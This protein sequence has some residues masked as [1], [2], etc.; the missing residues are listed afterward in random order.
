MPSAPPVRRTECS[1]EPVE[2]ESSA[3]WGRVS[4]RLL[5]GPS[6]SIESRH[7]DA[8]IRITRP[9]SSPF[10]VEEP[11]PE[12][13]FSGIAFAIRPAAGWSQPTLQA[14]LLGVFGQ[15]QSASCQTWLSTEHSFWPQTLGTQVRVSLYP[16]PVPLQRASFHGVR[17]IHAWQPAGRTQV[18]FDFVLI[19]REEPSVADEALFRALAALWRRDTFNISSTSR[20]AMH[21]A[22]QRVI[23]MGSIAVPLILRELQQR[24]DWWFWALQAIT[25]VDPVPPSWR[26]SLREMSAAWLAW[27]QEY[28]YLAR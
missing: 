23:G 3:T 1:S 20:M 10:L 28:G 17:A 26:G 19:D 16:D 24:P 7:V 4:P 27:G 2:F 11:D 15:L 21:P 18:P 13:P 5:P 25:G 6:G 14:A 9:R 22:Y 8:L 12:Q